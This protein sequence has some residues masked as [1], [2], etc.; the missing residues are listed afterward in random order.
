MRKPAVIGV[1]LAMSVSLGCGEEDPGRSQSAVPITGDSDT[2][3]L[4]VREN[5]PTYDPDKAGP[6]G[7]GNLGQNPNLLQIGQRVIA[8]CVKRHNHDDRG[9][10][11]AAKLEGETF[12]DYPFAP[13]GVETAG[14]QPLSVFDKPPD[15]VRTQLP[16]C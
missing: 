3:S 14:G 12:E 15:E 13:L 2:L 5:I 8:T 4:V 16:K 7:S 6:K 1:A 11:D 10:A 9:L